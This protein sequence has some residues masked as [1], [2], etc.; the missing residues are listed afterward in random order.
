MTA[1][2]SYNVSGLLG[3]NTI[4]T[5]TL[6]SQLVQAAAVP[7]TQL[8][9]Q[10]SQ[11]QSV[12]SAYQSINSK[13]T[14]VQTAAQAML[15][16]A[17]WNATAAVSNN[18]AVVA[19]STSGA[20]VGTTTFDV[21]ALASSQTVTVA[22][23]NGAMVSSSTVPMTVTTSSGTYDV[24]LSSSDTPAAIAAAINASAH[25]VHASVIKTST[26]D[27]LQ[28]TSTGT[29]VSNGS[30]KLGVGRKADG[31]ADDSVNPFASTPQVLT[32]AADASITVGDPTK[33]GYTVTSSTNTFTD[34]I[35]GVTF[36]VAA[37]A[38]GVKVS[39]SS[40]PSSI[41]DKVKSLVDAVNA[42]R[43]EIGND[44]GQGG[45]LQSR[46]EVSSLS[47]ALGSAVS[48][49]P[50]KISLKSF[51]I[52]MDKNGVLSF[53]PSAFSSAYAASPANTQ[54]A[55]TAFATSLNATAT[56]AVAPTT[57]TITS[58]IAAAATH[59]K[60]LSD[61]IDSWSTRLSDLQS[62][63]QTKYAAMNTALAKLQSQQTY[64]TSVLK[65]QANSGSNN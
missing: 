24:P 20:Q 53:D 33:G 56:A 59:S 5:T 38:T 47:Q 21:T 32:P 30:F 1:P 44:S 40:D 2:S 34:A 65:A 63:L 16:P 35:P 9:T 51:G 10:L 18:T 57:G 52:D 62:R 27:I 43:T 7:Q 48:S 45:V 49:L 22:A 26:G 42:A 58:S 28:I 55:I 13:V 8:K 54:S 17:T 29:G 6:V 31:T 3:S 64:L 61:Q 11:E 46:Y 15:D 60:S 23:S 12:L 19:S 14:A 50:G 36:S 37:L 39:V 41:S 4:D 25:G